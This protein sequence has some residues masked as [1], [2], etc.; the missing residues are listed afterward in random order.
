MS[1]DLSKKDEYLCPCFE[2]TSDSLDDLINENPGINY[3]DFLKK[4]KAGTKCTACLLDLEFQYVLRSKNKVRH[5]RFPL[6]DKESSLKQRIYK[7][8]D[9][10]T[11]LVPIRFSNVLPVII[12]EEVVQWVLLAN[13]SLLYK[14]GVTGSPMQVEIVVR[15]CRG[16][17]KFREMYFLD[18]ESHLRVN[19]SKYLKDDQLCIQN[20]SFG[21]GSVDVIRVASKV[22]CR[23]TT[24]PQIEVEAPGGNCMVHGQAASSGK[25][26]R[27]FSTIYRPDEDR[28]FLSIINADKI[29]I[30]FQI[31][32]PLNNDNIL[33]DQKI[34][35]KILILAGGTGLYEINLTGELRE[36]Y[37]N[38]VLTIGWSSNGVKQV[39]VICASKSIDSFSIDHL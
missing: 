29:D 16:E 8:F 21:I 14:R 36:S 9:R 33:E 10:L 25:D 6:I 5:F 34:T 28:I 24:R 27:N 20:D 13:Y 31:I 37:K 4:T 19:V 38:K 23:G 12:K 3:E 18:G 2:V 32:F 22:G 35:D 11:P 30:L 26:Y 1:Q 7:A 15:N 17:V 39:H